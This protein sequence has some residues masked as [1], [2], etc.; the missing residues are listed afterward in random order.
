MAEEGEDGA[1]AGAGAETGA[2]TGAAVVAGPIKLSRFADQMKFSLCCASLPQALSVFCIY[3]KSL[4]ICC[5]LTVCLY[6][7]ICMCI[8]VCVCVCIAVLLC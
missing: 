1:G 8:C 7:Y 4:F 6:V 3:T 2:G 5:S